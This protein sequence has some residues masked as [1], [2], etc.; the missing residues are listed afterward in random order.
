MRKLPTV[1]AAI[2]SGCASTANDRRMAIDNAEP[3]L[4]AQSATYELHVRN[5]RV[6]QVVPNP[7]GTA[8]VRVVD[9][10]GEFRQLYVDATGKPLPDGGVGIPIEVN[11]WVGLECVRDAKTC[12]TQPA[13]AP[14][15]MIVVRFH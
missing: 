14:R 6:E 10:E 4:I 15:S 7:D 12:G 13:D 2:L 5:G 11:G 3:T 8:S 1:I 9:R